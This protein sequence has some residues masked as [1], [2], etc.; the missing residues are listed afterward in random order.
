M[1]IGEFI[2]IISF[3][4][5]NALEYLILYLIY[6]NTLLALNN[7]ISIPILI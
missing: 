3:K 1:E 5:V 6:Y 7:V 2:I 4:I